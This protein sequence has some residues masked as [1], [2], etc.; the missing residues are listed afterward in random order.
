MRPRVLVTGAA[1]FVGEACAAEFLRRSWAV[2]ALIHRQPPR[3]LA[4]ACLLRASL[5]DL[6]ELTAALTGRGPFDAIVHCAGYACDVGPGR[7]F[8][9][10][11]LGVRNL[12][13]LMPQLPARRLVHVSTTDVYGL[14][15]FRQ[16]DE[17]TPLEPHPRNPYPASKIQAERAITAWLAP[18]QYVILRPGLVWGP[19]DK[20][21]LPRVLSYL[22]R[23]S[24]I[25]H[26]GRHRGANRWPLAHVR[27]LARAAALAATC[28]EAAGAAYNVV[29]PER[30][31]ADEYFRLVLHHLLPGRPEPG[32]LTLPYALGW[33]LAAA[34][35][36]LSAIL[37]RRH[38]LFEPSLYG[39]ASATS[40]LDF[41]S[42]KLQR[43][44]AAHGEAFVSRQEGF[45]E[46]RAAHAVRPDR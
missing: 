22:A 13:D 8:R 2:T 31:T 40:D 46:L 9:V 18:G 44:F 33:L 17:D 10:N 11:D 15:D 30:T 28:D 29:D 41:S 34:S 45:E 43:L 21:I 36:A 23:S 26:F 19:G 24:S 7:A 27:N 12:I 4:G 16:A 1:G 20:T 35:T 39:L 3:G 42:R 6:P 32:S 14:R 25:I 5:T 37:R 38:P